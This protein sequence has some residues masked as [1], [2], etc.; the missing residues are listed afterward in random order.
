MDS[1]LR[2]NDLRIYLCAFAIIHIVC[3][4]CILPLSQCDGIEKGLRKT[5]VSSILRVYTGYLLRTPGILSTANFMHT[6]RTALPDREI[7]M[8]GV[9][10]S[11]R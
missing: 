7:I 1:S 10:A 2:V 9:S 3:L 5:F 6:P 11:M 8:N 4:P